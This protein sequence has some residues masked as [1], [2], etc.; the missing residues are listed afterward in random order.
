MKTFTWKYQLSLCVERSTVFRLYIND[1]PTWF[2]ITLEA[3]QDMR[4]IT[5]SDIET[6]L[7]FCLCKDQNLTVFEA[8]EAL[9]AL[10]TYRGFK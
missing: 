4:A 5:G 2:H 9:Q 7:A 1:K 3:V 10:Q 8:T 6:E